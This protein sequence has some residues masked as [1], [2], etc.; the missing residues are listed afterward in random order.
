MTPIQEEQ[1]LPPKPPLSPFSPRG[2]IDYIPM[3]PLAIALRETYTPTEF[4]SKGVKK[5]LGVVAMVAIPFAAPAIATASGLS[6]FLA[7]T[8]VSTASTWVAP[9][10]VGAGLGAV[11]AKVTGTDPLKGAIGGAIGGGIGGFVKNLGVA[12]AA[13]AGTTGAVNVVPNTA[14]TLAAG[15]EGMTSG[16]AGLNT[17]TTPAATVAAVATPLT[18]KEALTQGLKSSLSSGN[19]ATAAIQMG[20]KLM[21]DA[22]VAEDYTE[23]QL[24]LIEK[25]QAIVEQLEAQG[26]EVDQIKLAEA[27]NLLQQALQVSPAYLARQKEIAMKNRYAAAGT[28]A[29]RR[30]NTAGIRS[31]Y[32]D[33]I[34]RRTHL[35]GVRAA[36]SEYDAGMQ[37]G[38]DKKTG[39]I[40]AGV[41]LLPPKTPLSGYY[42]NMGT[43]Y[44]DWQDDADEE[45]AGYQ[46]LFGD[47]FNQK[48]KKKTKTA[49]EEDIAISS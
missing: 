25:Q 21:M 19:L 22:F 38:L 44:A 39:L 35:E 14:A 29:V 9:A 11:A 18:F 27:R 17:L 10:L 46:S 4:K 36:A 2:D 6:G 24:A 15:G 26:Q 41:G 7:T 20:G 5:V 48:R 40:T 8:A 49:G 45:L 28:E 37:A 3:S 47:A 42:E 32:A 43:M 1:R 33:N 31:N 16:L 30:A 13:T 23:E 12:N 34:A